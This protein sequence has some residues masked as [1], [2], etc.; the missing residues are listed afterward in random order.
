M[1]NNL[2]GQI[3]QVFSLFEPVGGW[4]EGADDWTKE[5]QQDYYDMH[6]L[7]NAKP[8]PLTREQFDKFCMDLKEANYRITFWMDQQ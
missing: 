4:P 3:K 2:A 5:E 8:P 6:S 7:L 1:S